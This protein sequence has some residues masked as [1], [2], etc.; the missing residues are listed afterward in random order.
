[1]RKAIKEE[2]AARQRANHE[3][4]QQLREQGWREVSEARHT[5]G[6]EERVGRGGWMHACMCQ[7]N[8]PS[9]SVPASKA[10]ACTKP[11]EA[12]RAVDGRACG[13]A[14]CC[15]TVMAHAR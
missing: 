8:V 13:P 7:V 6:Q 1:M 2:E 10:R 11:Q 14:C 4:M 9:W 12:A 5:Q 3:F 15:C